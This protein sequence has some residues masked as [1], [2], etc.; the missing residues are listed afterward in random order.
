MLD[1]FGRTG[2]LDNAEEFLTSMKGEWDDIAITTLL[3]AC[4]LKVIF[5]ELHCFHTYAKFCIREIL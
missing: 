1:A 4:R 3:S 5:P 2:E